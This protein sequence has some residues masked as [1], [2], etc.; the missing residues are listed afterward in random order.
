VPVGEDV[1]LDDDFIA[2]G[3]LDGIA[4]A[5]DLW[6]DRLDDDARRWVLAIQ[7]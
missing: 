1:R 4:P 7:A 3:A 5:V 6:Q 2:D